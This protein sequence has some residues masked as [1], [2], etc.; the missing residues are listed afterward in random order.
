MHVV[1]GRGL[2]GALGVGGGGGFVLLLFEGVGWGVLRDFV[3]SLYTFF[4]GG[5]V[6]AL[7][8]LGSLLLV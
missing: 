7:G 2:G 6:E 4:V 3:C 1:A 5:G 8:S